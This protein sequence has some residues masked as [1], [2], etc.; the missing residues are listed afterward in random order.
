MMRRA[1]LV[2]A[3][4]LAATAPA[5]AAPSPKAGITAADWGTTQ[6]GEKVRLF[7]LT[8]RGGM[9]ARMLRRCGSAV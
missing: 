1:A 3:A 9:V 8:G 2:A 5:L 7:T 4:L 6:K